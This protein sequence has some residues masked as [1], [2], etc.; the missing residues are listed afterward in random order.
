MMI[1]RC[2]MLKYIKFKD[3]TFKLF[4]EDLQHI[5]EC[6]KDA[7]SAGFVCSL[8]GSMKCIGGSASLNLMS[9]E[10]DTDAL[11]DWLSGVELCQ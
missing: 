5:D 1:G 4:S 6:S 3:G 7:Q 10:G 9:A 8:H 11:S 2:E